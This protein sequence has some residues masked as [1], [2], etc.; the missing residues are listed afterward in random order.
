MT[1][2]I[3]IVLMLGALAALL[4]VVAVGLLSANGDMED[5]RVELYITNLTRGQVLSPVFITRHDGTAEPL[6]SLGQPP[7][8]ALAVMAEDADASGLLAQWNPDVNAGISE[9]RVLTLED[10]PIPPGHTAKLDFDLGDGNSMVS[11]VSMLVTTNDAFIGAN[12]LD[13]SEDRTVNLSAYD[14]GSEANSEDCDF[15]PGPPCGNHRED[16]GVAEG[17]VYVHP[18]ITGGGK[19]DLDRELHDWRNPV[20]RLTVKAWNTPAADSGA[21]LPRLLDVY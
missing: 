15:I 20:A 14:A 13:I 8:D 19:S 18:G 6:Y 16:S 12:G 7:T 10:G 4:V 11:L 1:R 17:Y 3:S 21:P 9:S 5:M 2:T